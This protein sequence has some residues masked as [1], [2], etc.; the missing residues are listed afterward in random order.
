MSLDFGFLTETPR[1]IDTTGAQMEHHV[2]CIFND[3]EGTT[4]KVFQF[5]MPLK[6]IYSEN[7]DFIEYK[8]IFDHYREVQTRKT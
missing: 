5:I 8:S 7:L 2:F 6:S 3:C 4:E 1:N